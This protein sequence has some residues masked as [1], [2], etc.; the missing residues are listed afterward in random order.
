MAFYLSNNIDN[1]KLSRILKGVEL[2]KGL[3]ELKFHRNDFKKQSDTNEK[4]QAINLKH[5][6]Q[7][8]QL[9]Q[10]SN[11]IKTNTTIKTLSLNNVYVGLNAGKECLYDFCKAL[12]MNKIITE[13][14][15]T[16]YIANETLAKERDSLNGN[17]VFYE[18]A[19]QFNEA[20]C[21]MK[22]LK[23]LSVQFVF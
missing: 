5:Y 19:S 13:L 12:K 11:M 18:W 22:Q 9:Q 4:K 2:C 6:I 3:T 15:I 7:P 23:T 10:I 17:S 20:V 16:F 1:T 14:D 21:E 8:N